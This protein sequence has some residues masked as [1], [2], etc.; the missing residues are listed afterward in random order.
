M[1]P[2]MEFLRLLNLFCVEGVI[3][4]H[5]SWNYI[6]CIAWF[7]LGKKKGLNAPCVGRIVLN[8][9]PSADAVTIPS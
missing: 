1:N 3:A 2:L 7:V 6:Q 8:Y 9:R 4:K 5:S